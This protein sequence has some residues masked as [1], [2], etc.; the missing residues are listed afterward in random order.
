MHPLE[1][2]DRMDLVADEGGLGLLSTAIA[3]CGRK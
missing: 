3:G 1:A 2:L